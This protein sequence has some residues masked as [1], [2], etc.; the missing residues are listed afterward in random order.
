MANHRLVTLIW[1]FTE[2]FGLIFLSMITF[3]VF[4]RLLTPTEL[5]IGTVIIAIVEIVGMLYSS[6]LEDPLVRME[7][8][9][10]KHI[11]TTFWFAVLI[12]LASIVVISLAAVLYTPSPALQWMTAVASV[13]ILFTMMARV[14]VVEMR[15]TSNFKRLASRTLLGKIAGGVGGIGVALL[16]Y[17]P[18]AVIAQALIMDFVCVVVLMLADR[19]RIAFCIDGPILREL[20][21]SGTPVAINVLSSQTLQR[22]V[23][24]VLGMTA[25]AHAVGMFN[26]AMRIIDL[27]RTAIYNGL[28]SYALPVFARRIGDPPRL[29]GM[30]SDSTAISGF[31]LT[32]FFLGIALTAEDIILLI[33]GA[34]WAAAVPLLQ[35]LAGTAAL[36]NLA[37]YATTA[38]VAVNHTRVTLKAEVITTLL[39]LALVYAMGPV[40]GGMGAALALLVRM[41]IITPLQVRGLNTAIGYGWD[42]FFESS[43]RSVIA[44]LVMATAV[45]FASSHLALQGYLHLVGNIAIGAVTYAMAYSVLHPR[46]P[47]EFK[48]VFTAR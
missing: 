18:W 36:G 44:S 23:N 22:G 33:F 42:A 43:Y 28:M 48:L 8:L 7:R 46:W 19:R 6:V 4:A 1:I 24:V 29:I 27:P 30:I 26:L 47:Q 10:A 39:A 15:R 34:K 16:G 32:P 41:L 38:L 17:G 20:L 37:M 9:E 2:K 3:V 35:V 31:L 11:S 12:S 5:G 45:L 21:K 40:Y 14:Y 25:G 13:K